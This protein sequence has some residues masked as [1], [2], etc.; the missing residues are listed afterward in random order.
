MGA[1]TGGRSGE[2]LTNNDLWRFDWT[3]NCWQLVPAISSPP[4]TA[5]GTALLLPTGFNSSMWLTDAQPLIVV[6]APATI[7]TG[8]GLGIFTLV[9]R[10]GFEPMRSQPCKPEPFPELS[11]F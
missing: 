1:V 8:S 3:F 10:V 4:P 9:R 6:A 11:P 2:A 5:Y 7:G